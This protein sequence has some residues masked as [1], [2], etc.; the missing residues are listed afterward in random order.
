MRDDKELD[1]EI[2]RRVSSA[3]Q[4]GRGRTSSQ[5]TDDEQAIEEHAWPHE[6]P[7]HLLWCASVAVREPA[8]AFCVSCEQILDGADGEY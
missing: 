7:N 1:C 2:T 4:R 3:Q 6:Q 8:K 5:K